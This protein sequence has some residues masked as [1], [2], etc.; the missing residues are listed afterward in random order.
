MFHIIRSAIISSLNVTF[1][2]C[3]EIF[4]CVRST[5]DWSKDER[6]IKTEIHGLLSKTLAKNK[7]KLKQMTVFC[8][9]LIWFRCKHA[10]GFKLIQAIVGFHLGPFVVRSLSTLLFFR[11]SLS[12]TL[13][14]FVVVVV[15]FVIAVMRMV[16]SPRHPLTRKS[17]CSIAFNQRKYTCDFRPALHFLTWPQIIRI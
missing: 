2:I 1:S 3:I 16:F 8:F 11:L 14:P 5:S 4:F 12:Y 13:S 6:E 7:N 9:Y 15:V 10:H 17:S